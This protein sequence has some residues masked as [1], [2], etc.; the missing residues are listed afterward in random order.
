LPSGGE[1]KTNNM[2]RRHKLWA[3]AERLR[4]MMILGSKCA[5]CG[6]TKHLEFDCLNP[7]GDR[8]HRMTAPARVSFYRA[9]MRAANVQ[10]LCKDCNSLK[11]NIAYSVWFTGLQMQRAAAAALPPPQYPARGPAWSPEMIRNWLR[12]WLSTNVWNRSDYPLP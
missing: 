10:L 6:A 8:H 12:R 9:Q 2:A 1:F 4:M 7:C 3:Q 11:G 5:C